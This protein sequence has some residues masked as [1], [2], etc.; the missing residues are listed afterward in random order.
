MHPTSR[1]SLY[2]EEWERIMD[3]E[4]VD[5]HELGKLPEIGSE[6]EDLMSLANATGDLGSKTLDTQT[7]SDLTTFNGSIH[8]QAWERSRRSQLEARESKSRASEI[9]TPIED[10]PREYAA[11][12]RG[13][14][15]ER[16]ESKVI[17]VAIGAVGALFAWKLWTFVIYV[18]SWC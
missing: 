14:A 5:P 18:R 4:L 6:E 2:G 1:V 11:Y 10:D 9:C 3:G 7:P 12:M 13:A 17:W 15:Q 8:D 16:L